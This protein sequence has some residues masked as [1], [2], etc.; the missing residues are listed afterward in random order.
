MSRV[1]F[2]KQYI[3]KTKTG[4][5]KTQLHDFSMTFHD[6]QCNLHDYL[7][8]GLQPPLLAASSPRCT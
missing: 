5:S 6:Q 3:L 1:N 7:M 8:H 4:N 2:D